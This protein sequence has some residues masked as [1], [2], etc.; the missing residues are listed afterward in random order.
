MF[1]STGVQR[2]K[3]KCPQ[4]YKYRLQIELI[5]GLVQLVSMDGLKW[6]RNV[7]NHVTRV[8][9]SAS[10]VTCRVMLYSRSPLCVVGGCDRW[11]VD[12]SCIFRST[13]PLLSGQSPDLSTFVQL[14]KRNSL[15]SQF[16]LQQHSVR[17]GQNKTQVIVKNMGKDTEDRMFVLKQRNQEDQQIEQEEEG[18]K[19]VLKQKRLSEDKKVYEKEKGRE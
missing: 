6:K 17:G 4:Y 5:R 9:S 3:G 10:L 19:L 15:T 7:V 8:A 14:I 11:P 12:Y 16:S 1:L 18:R 2:F 13:F